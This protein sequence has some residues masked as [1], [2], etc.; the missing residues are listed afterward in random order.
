M[1][2]EFVEKVHDAVGLQRGGDD[3]HVFLVLRP[4]TAVRASHLL[5]LHPRVR[6]LL[7]LQR[8]NCGVHRRRERNELDGVNSRAFLNAN[9]P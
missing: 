3:D 5:A 1:C 8:E 2:V 7:E 9:V 4:M 6:Q